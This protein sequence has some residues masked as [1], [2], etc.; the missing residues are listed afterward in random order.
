MSDPTYKY[1]D[2]ADTFL[3]N[4]IEFFPSIYGTLTDNELDTE[5]NNLILPTLTKSAEF[6]TSIQ[7]GVINTRV[8]GQGGFGIVGDFQITED[9]E[10]QKVY[11]II[12]SIKPTG[13]L[14][15][16]Y[17]PVIIKTGHQDKQISFNASVVVDLPITEFP[18]S[19]GVQRKIKIIAISDPITEIVFGS[20]LGHL[21][22]LGLC[23]FYAKYFSAYICEVRCI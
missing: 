22:D 14:E 10:N 20:M 2:D 1:F 16:F 15:P 23:P 18:H 4:L 13:S 11:A 12:V 7:N 3:A 5:I 19:S 6:C 9:Q 21:Y 17:V 8:T